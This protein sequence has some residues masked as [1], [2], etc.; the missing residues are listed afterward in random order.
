M[1]TNTTP[2]NSDD[3]TLADFIEGDGPDLFS[4]ARRFAPF[5]AD[6][7]GKG[8]YLYRRVVSSS[9]SDVVSVEESDG[10][11]SREMVM[12]SSNNYLG[13]N[14]RPE[15]TEAAISAIR[16][17]GTSMCGAP[18]L[19][20][21]YDLVKALERRLAEFEGRGD[22]MIFS[23]GYQA[24]VGVIAGLLRSRDV[25]IIDKLSHASIVDGCKLAHCDLRAFR[26]SD[27]TDLERIL[28]SCQAKYDGKLIVTDGVFSMDGDR[29]KLPEIVQLAKQYGARVLVD[30]AHGIGVLGATGRGTVE[31]FGL[32]D[33][34]DLIMGTFSK[35]LGSTGGYIAGSTEVVDYLRHYARSYIFSASPTPPNVAAALAALEL[36]QQEPEL[37]NRLWANIRYVHS[38]LKERGFRVFPDQPESAIMVI[39]VGADVVLRQMSREVHNAGVFVSSVIYPAVARNESRLRISL[40][41]DHTREELDKALDVLTVAG[42]RYG[43]LVKS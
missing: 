9:C 26:H 4:K 2:I 23:T 22:A 25:V 32:H 14:T 42:R 15:V 35:T 3:F 12:L 13:L 21:T 33:G 39:V 43:V 6:W 28:K 10:G 27:M 1:N 34:V 40:T 16:K 7:R 17:Y 18:H 29:A 30:E 24:N 31:H 37:R 38:A 36:V 19:N 11:S 20:G 41:A 5:F 8:T